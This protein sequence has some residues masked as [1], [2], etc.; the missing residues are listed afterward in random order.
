MSANRWFFRISLL[1][2]VLAF[3]VV[4]LG[5]FVRLSNAGLG[6]PDWPGCY[7]HIGVPEASQAV[8]RAN[9]AYPGRP[10]VA[11]KGWKEMIHRYF[12]GT[13]GL[14]IAA[15]AAL[16]WRNRRRTG[17]PVGVP[18]FL[19]L[20]VIVQAALGM[21]T[22]TWKLKPV[23]VMGHLLGGLTVLS[24]LWWQ[25]L[26][27]GRLLPRLTLPRVA[28]LK[29]ALAIGLIVVVCQIALGGWTSSNYAAVACNEFPTCT[30]GAYWPAD[31]D[32]AS[33]F[34]LWHRIGPDYEYGQH[35]SHQAK[36]A[37]HLTHR[38]GALVTTVFVVALALV[39][40]RAVPGTASNVAAVVLA[41][42]LT[43]QVVLG[44]SNVVFNLPLPVAVAHN[45]GAALL[46]L[47]FVTLNHL[48]RPP[49]AP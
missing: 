11:A 3:G 40:W 15:A 38:L 42:V 10:V 20:M 32:F 16:A 9:A 33:G 23:V 48:V 46:L 49:E 18:L 7:G 30:N 2:T 19:V 31:A 13:L 34:T 41:V 24:L 44:I 1:A 29:A 4:S 45:A 39:L 12:A 8:A 21:W 37:I 22:V 17:Q 5:A 14:L 36:E 28:G 43:L 47:V 27:A 26:R 35:L 25:T 6:C